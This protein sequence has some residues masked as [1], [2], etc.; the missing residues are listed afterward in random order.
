MEIFEYLERA[1]HGIR[2]NADARKVR[3]ELYAHLRFVSERQQA[4]GMPAEESIRE[5]MR[6]LGDPDVLSRAFAAQMNGVF[7]RGI[8][9]SALALGG[10]VAA[11]GSLA[12]PWWL[13]GLLL[14]AAVYALLRVTPEERRTPLLSLLRLLRRHWLVGAALAL[15]GFFIGSEP[16]WGAGVYSPWPFAAQATPAGLLL[17]LFGVAALGLDLY[18]RPAAAGGIVAV[19][20]S[21]FGSV[22]LASGFVLWH[23][24]PAAPSQNVDWFASGPPP[25]S[26]TYL[27][28]QNVIWHPVQFTAVCFLGSLVI[29][30]L[31][32]FSRSWLPTFT[33]T[34]HG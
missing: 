32:G 33:R 6:R 16:I 7:P 18:R 29:A 13:L 22:S 3:S 26:F 23:F 27:V 1:T 4:E 8:A 20:T 9:Q 2:S 15:A 11:I 28:Y 19:A 14:T 5:A 30:G 17:L 10:I 21:V 31:I 34:A 25:Y 24:Y 12:D